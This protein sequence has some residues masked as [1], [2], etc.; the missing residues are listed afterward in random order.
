MHNNWQTNENWF[1]QVTTNPHRIT[2]NTD[3]TS[4]SISNDAV[5]HFLFYSFFK[6]IKKQNGNKK[7]PVDQRLLEKKAKNVY[8]VTFNLMMYSS[9]FSTKKV[10]NFSIS[11]SNNLMKSISSGD[12]ASASETA[13]SSNLGRLEGLSPGLLGSM[14][15]NLFLRSLYERNLSRHS[16]KVS[17]IW[18]LRLLPNFILKVCVFCVR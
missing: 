15:F 17:S 7:N 9:S 2:R 11:S 12:M 18:L 13:E 10:L 14:S 1:T 3:Y 8:S 16:G 4:G 5:F 6:K